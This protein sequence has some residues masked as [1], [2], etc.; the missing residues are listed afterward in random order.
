MPGSL[1]NIPLSSVGTAHVVNLDATEAETGCLANWRHAALQRRPP[2]LLQTPTVDG[3]YPQEGRV[4]P[5]MDEGEAGELAAPAESQEA[6]AEEGKAAVAA[7]LAAV[8]AA[9][10]QL[11]HTVVAGDAVRLGEDVL[12]CYL[13]ID[14]AAAF[15]KGKTSREEQSGAVRN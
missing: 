12:E 7:E 10:G 11:P 4:F 9:I 2:Q 13:E 14:R 6:A 8:E 5:Y 3:K 1:G 15:F